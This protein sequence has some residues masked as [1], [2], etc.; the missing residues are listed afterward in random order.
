[1][2][3][4]ADPLPLDGLG[5][6][7]QGMAHALVGAAPWPDRALA[8]IGALAPG[9]T[10]TADDLVAAVGLPR[11]QVAKERNN[12]VGAV[13]SA[14]HRARMTRRLSY[15][16]ARRRDSHARVIGLWVRS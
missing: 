10:F 12:A 1:M 16:S 15:V 6:R 8:W 7:D 5:L 2:T 4:Q 9:A 11:G 14:A 13:I 3:W